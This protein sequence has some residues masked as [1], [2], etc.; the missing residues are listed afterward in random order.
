MTAD[1]D[2][3]KL[4]DVIGK[5][6]DS[7]VDP[8]LWPTALESACALIGATLGYIIQFDTQH[9]SLEVPQHWGGDD[10][11]IRKYQELVPHMPFWE[12]MPRYQIGEI[13]H[14]GDL[15]K[16]TG[17]SEAEMLNSKFFRE[18][19]QPYALRDV[20]AGI[21]VNAGERVG[22]INMH[23][24]LTRDVVGPRD[25]AVMELLLPHARRAITIGNLLDMKA[26]ANAAF[27]ATLNT[28]NTP[29]VLVDANSRILQI[30]LA[31]ERML[32]TGGPI[33]SSRGELTTHQPDATAAL[34]SAITRAASNESELGYGGIGVPIKDATGN[35][36]ATRPSIAHVLPL[37]SGK[38]RPGLSLGAVAA[39]FVSPT[40]ETTAA[41]VEALAA[42]YDLTPMEARVMIEIAAGKNRA[43]TAETLGIADSTVKTHLAR[44][45]EK[46]HRSD[47]SEL[48]KLVASL[49]PP[50]AGGT[51]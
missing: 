9:R 15:L 36:A 7:A 8:A 26:L 37:K 22:S 42:L 10:D 35:K 6:Y 49:T 24:P 21:V 47:Q 4:S 38:L 18:W 2:A 40:S 5:I 51:S 11:V 32:S 44:V 27:E 17:L 41:P 33:L 31:A 1:I 30:N 16:K 23:T 48:A 50:V 19:A 25:I 46:T 13:A 28:L 43:A 39:V 34:R 45:F 3:G 29:I 14:T 12:V 20:V